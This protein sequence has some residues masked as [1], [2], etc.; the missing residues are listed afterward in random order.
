MRHFYRCA[1]CLS[2]VATDA[3]I[4]PVQ[5]PPAYIRSFGEC[6]A[7]DGRIEYLGQVQRDYLARTE[8]RVP[9]DARCTS[10]IGPHCEC[11]CGGVNHGSNRV[12]EVVVEV[13]KVPRVMVPPDAKVKAETYRALVQSVRD[14]HRVRFGRVVELKRQ[15]AYLSVP[16]WCL[17]QEG[18]RLN[19]RIVAARE[20][21]SHAARNRK[22]DAIL[23]DII[24]SRVVGVCA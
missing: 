6:G 14:A 10:A 11:Q 21:R 7:C 15:G 17:F 2:V 23:A 19:N 5:L 8:L 12:V 22:L 16:D 9:C 24:G 4:Q 3:K 1:D 18:V 13:G 20:L